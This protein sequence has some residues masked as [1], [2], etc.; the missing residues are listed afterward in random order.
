MGK[1]VYCDGKGFTIRTYEDDTERVPC[2][3]CSVDT[4]E[5]ARL[6]AGADEFDLTVDAFG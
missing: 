2:P 1:C 4:H 6:R 3:V 5:R